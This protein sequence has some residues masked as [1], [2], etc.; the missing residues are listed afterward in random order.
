M[1]EEDFVLMEEL[2]MNVLRL[3][4]M[5][6]G[7]EPLE[8]HYNE[9][10]L[11]QIEEIVNLGSQHGIYT[12]LDMHQDGLSEF[13]CGEGLPTWAVRHTDYFTA[14]K[15]GYP[16]PF[17]SPMG[18]GDFY[19]EEDLPTKPTIPT[20]ASCSTKNQGPGWHEPT[21]ASANAYEAFYQNVD[22]MLDAWANM[23][24]HVGRSSS[25]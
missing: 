16:F 14:D 21:M 8:G 7:V 6:P 22:G 15:H 2:G 24:A 19:V 18:E 5:W 17:D 4:V 10:Y 25:T 9:T 11:D 12:L 23:W 3:G 20:R 13:F 1:A